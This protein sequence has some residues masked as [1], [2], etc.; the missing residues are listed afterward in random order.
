MDRVLVTHQADIPPEFGPLRSAVRKT[1]IGIR[2]A[3]EGETFILPWGTLVAQPQTDVIAVQESGEEY[4]IKIDIFR[5]TYDEVAPG[6]FRKKAVT[7][8]VQVPPGVLVKVETL[9]G[10]LEVV[11]PD[12]LVVGVKGEVYANNLEWVL[13]NLEFIAPS[14]S[15]A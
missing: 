8:L 10:N 13:Q 12:Y 14:S 2:E 11:H 3:L 6:R 15:A 9:E 4:P 1:T 5:D 7:K